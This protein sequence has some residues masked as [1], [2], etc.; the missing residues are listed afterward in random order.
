MR[1][2][3]DLKNLTVADLR[4]AIGRNR[5]RLSIAGA[6]FVI[7]LLLGFMVAPLILKGQIEKALSAATGQVATLAEVKVN[8]LTLSVQLLA[9]R[10]AEADG[11]PL[12]GVDDLYVNVQASS[13]FRAALVFG[14]ISIAGPWVNAVVEPDATLNLSRIGAT[15][16]PV[17]PPSGA[18]EEPPAIMIQRFAVTGGRI[19]YED[20]TQAKPT[21][22]E[23]RIVDLG[24]SDLST[25]RGESGSYTLEA[26]GERARFRWQGEVG[27]NPIASRGSVAISGLDL[28]N[29]QAEFAGELINGQVRSGKLQAATDYAVARRAD[30][31]FDFALS[32]GRATLTEFVFGARDAATAAAIEVTRIDLSGTSLDLRTQ[33]LRF[34]RVAITEPTL[35]A[36]LDAAGL[37]LAAL[38][39]PPP[40]APATVASAP[41]A[42]PMNAT[43]PTT[44]PPAGPP[45]RVALGEFVLAGGRVE[46][47]DTTPA[48]PVL[49]RIAPLA[50]ALRD[51]T[52]APELRGAF[53]LSAGINGGTLTLKGP[54]ALPAPA[55][56]GAAAQPDASLALKV[57]ALGLTPYAPYLAGVGAFDLYRGAFEAEGTVTLKAGQI[58]YA[59]YLGM[60]DLAL[61]DHA[62]KQDF[63]R[64][65]RLQL[66]SVDAKVPPAP[67]VL[68]LTIKEVVVEQPYL[69][70]IIGPD[71]VTNIDHILGTA[72]PPA[73]DAADEDESEAKPAAATV[74]PAPTGPVPK[75]RIASVRIV[76]GSA[77]F[78]D[79]SLTPAFAT[80]IGELN[81][82]IKGL[83][84]AEKTQAEVTID[85]RVDRYAPMTVRGVIN[86]LAAKPT[87]DLA[88][89]FKDIELTTFTPYSGK[90]MGMKIEQG[91]LSLDLRYKLVDRMLEGENK[92]ILD[93]FTLGEN[94]DS[95][96]AMGLPVRLAI[97]L[98]KDSRGVIDLDL[99]VKGSLDDPQFSYGKIVWKAFVSL[100]TKAVSAPFAAL[101]SM[102]GGGPDLEKVAFAPG[103]TVPDPTQQAQLDTIAKALAAKP[104]LRLDVPGASDPRLDGEVI[105]RKKVLG[106]V[107][108]D[109]SAP[110]AGTLTP[111]ELRALSE[112]F[113]AKFP[114]VDPTTVLPLTAEGKKAEPVALGAEQLARLAA[115]EP[116]DPA[117][118]A[119]LARARG[120]AIKDYLVSRA[121]LPAERIYLKDVNAVGVPK[122]GQVVVTLE[123][124]AP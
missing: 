101:G 97:A 6:L 20:L 121:G 93:Q 35:R 72:R 90:F 63:L 11:A 58:G 100:I 16:D 88:V 47:N 80:A 124:A 82:T 68:S 43:A 54:V 92:I 77:N 96:D 60:I 30:G 22:T 12:L 49:H 51:A 39:A 107:R 38:F 71:R 52:L 23:I 25:R 114:E 84:S 61:R 33:A 76:D 56:D 118:L 115:A 112:L 4:A 81:G 37:D 119:D 66:R 70:M 32:E 8:P 64:W 94:V 46:F 111:K 98:L 27:F 74:A 50:I 40:A 10:I 21:R 14:E 104:E 45:W 59:G 15:A 122:D 28:A 103:A 5:K 105:A 18:P 36:Q 13:V 55:A 67:Q 42:A 41:A 106:R 87:T 75:V 102:F 110:D 73:G 79:Q 83:S 7:Y 116:A 24:A 89:K 17:P 3:R 123:L 29:L 113:V 99:P 19:A 53:E 65:K 117:A 78:A 1:S 85:G 26:T 109:G 69:R 44:P 9:L 120:L 95:P 108:P 62:L 57:Q 2:Y 86:P 48:A 31:E 34:G 91:R